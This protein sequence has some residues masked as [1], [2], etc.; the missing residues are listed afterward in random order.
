[1]VCLCRVEG[2]V[3][4]NKVSYTQPL[5]ESSHNT[6]LRNMERK[7]CMMTQEKD[8]GEEYCVTI[9][10]MAALLETWINVLFEVF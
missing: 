9:L 10:K 1:M 3:A 2:G 7:C 4:V 6:S 8:C 5:C